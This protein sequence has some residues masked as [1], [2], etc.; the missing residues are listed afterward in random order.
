MEPKRRN[1]G[2]QWRNRPKVSSNLSKDFPWEVVLRFL[3]DHARSL[4]LLQMVDKNLNHLITTDH[5]LWL[6][7]FRQEIKSH[8]YCTRSIKDP[9]YPGLKLWKPH[10]T[11]LPVYSGPLPGDVDDASLKPGFQAEFSSY[12]RRAF[13]LKH[14]TRC[15]LCGCRYRHD[16]YWSLRMRVCRLCMENNSI[17][18]VQ[19]RRKYGVDFSELLVRHPGRFFFYSCGGNMGGD[20]RLSFHGMSRADMQ[21]PV[22]VFWM[23][24]LRRL[25]DFGE[26][27]QRQLRRRRAGVV[28][29]SAVRRRWVVAQQHLFVTRKASHSIDCLVMAL[30]RNEKKRSE[31]AYGIYVTAGGPTWAFPE[32]PRGN[33]KIT[34]RTGTSIAS[35]FRTVSEFED[36][37]VADAPA[38]SGLSGS[39]GV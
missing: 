27:Y 20:D 3:K 37:V 12:V 2:R 14:G 11:G 6:K 25:L 19:L 1:R 15:G 39:S 38:D 17:T 30:L 4:I 18:G 22:Y 23:P 24:H 16:P 10:L 26:M 28:L 21:N 5:A 35:Y 32:H 31:K 7:V 34:A 8:A 33:F 29:S 9:A 36:Y 13:A